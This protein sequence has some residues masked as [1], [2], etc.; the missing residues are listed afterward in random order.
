MAG[1]FFVPHS[2]HVWTSDA[3]VAVAGMLGFD[4]AWSVATCVAG[5]LLAAVLQPVAA[6]PVRTSAPTAAATTRPR[7]ERCVLGT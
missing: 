3:V 2:R 6:I 7:N 4:A 5:F 1:I